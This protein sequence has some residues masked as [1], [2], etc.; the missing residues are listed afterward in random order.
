MYELPVRC[1]VKWCVETGL[2]YVQRH[3]VHVYIPEANAALFTYQGVAK[4]C[5]CTKFKASMCVYLLVCAG[6]KKD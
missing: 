5:A 4:V 2:K 6:T 1:L 3:E